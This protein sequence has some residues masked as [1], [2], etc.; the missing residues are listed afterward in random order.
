MSTVLGVALGLVG[1]ALA[2]LGVA[3]YMVL[4]GWATEDAV[5]AAVVALILAAAAGLVGGLGSW[6]SRRHGGTLRP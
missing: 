4:D 2:M 5:A 3:L 1:A 6:L